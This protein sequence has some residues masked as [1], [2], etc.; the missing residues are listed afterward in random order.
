MI[1]TLKR[2]YKNSRLTTKTKL[3]YFLFPAAILNFGVKKSPVKVGFGTVE[4][5]KPHAEH[6]YSRWNFVSRW[7]RT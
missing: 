5:F 3:N 1:A 7:H 4:K 2:M 6:G